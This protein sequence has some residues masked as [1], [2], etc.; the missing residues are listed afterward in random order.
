MQDSLEELLI[1]NTQKWLSLMKVI[2]FR[3]RW[4]FNCYF[5]HKN[6]PTHLQTVKVRLLNVLA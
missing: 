1:P 5:T 2:H 3:R 6:G 4:T